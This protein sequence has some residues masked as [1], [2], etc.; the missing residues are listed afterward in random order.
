VKKQ[1]L[2]LSCSL[3]S[4]LGTGAVTH[5]A[6]GGLVLEEIIVSAQKRN[7]NLQDVPV[8]V[9][10]F[11]NETRDLIGISSI[12]DF[13]NFTPGVTYSTS[14]DRMNVRGVGRYT[15]NLSTSPGVATYGD[16]FYNYSNHQADTSALF[17]ERVEI[18]RGP[19]GTLYGRNSIGGAINVLMK[20]PTEDFRG[21]VRASA[22]NFQMM[23]GEGLFS[24]PITDKLSF[25]VGGGA[26]R[27]KEGFVE[28]IAGTD[29]E[30][31]HN[32]KFGLFELAYRAG[33]VA[34]V[35]FKYEYRKW[36]NGW[37]SAAQITPYNTTARCTP[38]IGATS[39]TPSLVASG[40]LG[41]SALYNNGVG[42]AAGVPIQGLRPAS[43]QYTTA[44]PGVLNNRQVNH[45]TPQHET[46]APSNQFTLE[47]NFHLGGADLK[48]IG[49]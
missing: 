12:Q 22:G 7:E 44:N 20:R 47:S 5:A 35:W 19:Q 31:E 34:D 16:G 42:I 2:V 41:P 39:C 27:Q 45:D 4:V 23:Q 14:T 29:E 46:L 36:D 11:T 48:Y 3:V 43:P 30:G 32:E 37:G 18:L 49:G 33:D 28:N 17:T 10:A 24:G 15:N 40:A 1:L 25:L 38:A 8:A 9:S 26:Y 13:T 6:E 21:E